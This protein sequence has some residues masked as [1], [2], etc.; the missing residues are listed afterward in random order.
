MNKKAGREGEREGGNEGGKEG[1]EAGTNGGTE[2]RRKGG[3]NGGTKGL[4][5][6]SI[7]IL[8][9]RALAR[10]ICL[11]VLSQGQTTDGGHTF[12]VPVH[13]MLRCIFGYA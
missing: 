2:E 7:A 6:S 11:L 5:T 3:K 9:Q 4:Q 8:A 1:E 13:T 10:V 12:V